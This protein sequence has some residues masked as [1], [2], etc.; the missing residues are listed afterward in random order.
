MYQEC[1]HYGRYHGFY[2]KEGHSSHAVYNYA[3]LLRYV[4]EPTRSK[5]VGTLIE[6]C[7]ADSASVRLIEYLAQK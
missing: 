3:E 6:K 5:S 7:A 4:D 1:R 2:R